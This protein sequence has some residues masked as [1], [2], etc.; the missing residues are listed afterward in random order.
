MKANKFIADDFARRKKLNPNFSLRAYSRW[1]GISP[2]QMSQMIKGTRTVTVNTL[3]KVVNRVGLSPLKR[4]HLF[5]SVF[6]NHEDVTPTRVS[7]AEDHFQLI[8]DWYHL[9]ILSLAKIKGAKGDPR[10]V[11]SRLGIP[12]SI[13]SEA[14]R[15]LERLGIL[16][17]HPRL[18]QITEPFVAVSAQPSVAIRNYHRQN[19][20]LAAEK[21]DTIPN[22]LREFQSLSFALDP[23][24]LPALRKLIDKFIE[25]S[26]QQAEEMPGVEVY[27]LNVQLFPVTKTKGN[28]A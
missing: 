19:L 3:T 6:L 10:W 8:S 9:A 12:V 24:Q 20:V 15:R 22:E 25:N 26:L 21:I 23:A 1:L 2:A 5:Q 11:A 13:A 27:H 14:M 18:R 7:L 28:K 16:Q 17:I 4:Q